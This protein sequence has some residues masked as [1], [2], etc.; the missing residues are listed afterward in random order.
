MHFFLYKLLIYERA[1]WNIY[2]LSILSYL[3]IYL[4]YMEKKKGQR[5]FAI[6]SSKIIIF[7]NRL[8]F[9]ISILRSFFS[10]EEFWYYAIYR[11]IFG[12]FSKNHTAKKPKYVWL[13]K[14][15]NEIKII[16]LFVHY[17]R[18]ELKKIVYFKSF[19][20]F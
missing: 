11:S 16:L 1:D 13:T 5:Y 2:I 12:F 6:K 7:E 3:T 4:P 14:P 8:G 18:H 15:T 10:M 19:K 9:V 17:R 20:N